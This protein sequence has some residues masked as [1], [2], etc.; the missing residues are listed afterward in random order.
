MQQRLAKE[1]A[2]F[3]DERFMPIVNERG[4][5]CEVDV[6]EEESTES[7]VDAVCHAAADLDAAVIV[8]ASHKKSRLEQ[9]L[10]G[11]SSRDVAG[12]A[13]IPVLVFHG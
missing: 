13:P 4:V 11:S 2:L 3:I 8:V 10:T 9:L 5:D 7:I 6:V 12:N 1:A